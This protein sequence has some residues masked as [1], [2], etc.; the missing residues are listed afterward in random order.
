ALPICR[1]QFACRDGGTTCADSDLIPVRTASPGERP[2]AQFDGIQLGLYVQDER[3][4]TDDLRL[5]L[6]LRADLPLFPTEPTENPLLSGTTGVRPDG[7]TFE[8]GPAFTPEA[9]EAFTR[10]PYT[11]EDYSDLSTANVPSGNL[12]FSPRLGVNYQT[13]GLRG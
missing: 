10:R 4:V 1:L 7:S 11:G 2:P 6:G 3:D 8:I 13:T 5:T 12:L 9:Y